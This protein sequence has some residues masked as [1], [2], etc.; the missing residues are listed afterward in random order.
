MAAILDD[1]EAAKLLLSHKANP[2]VANQ[3]G[4]SPLLEAASFSTLETFKVLSKATTSLQLR[5]GL[6]HM[7]VMN[8]CLEVF[9]LVKSEVD[10][11]EATT[12]F[13]RE[14]KWL[15]IFFAVNNNADVRI[16]EYLAENGPVNSENE[17]G[18]SPLTIAIKKENTEA[19]K[20]LLSAGADKDRLNKFGISARQV[21]D[22]STHFPTRSLFI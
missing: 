21:A 1:C 13:P 18:E 16:L 14:P 8:P 22:A 3:I 6:L 7:A 9:N 11:K 4:N 20:F 5:K 2:N 17:A 12:L 10:P 19:I 15:P